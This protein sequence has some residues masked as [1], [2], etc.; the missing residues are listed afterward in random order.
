MSAMPPYHSPPPILR[1]FIRLL[2]ALLLLCQAHGTWAQ[3]GW[4][5]LLGGLTDEQQEVQRQSISALGRSDY[6]GALA[7]LQALKAGRGRRDEEGRFFLQEGATGGAVKVT[8]SG[9][10]QATGNTSTLTKIIITN[11]LR[12]SL[13]TAIAQQQ[14]RAKSPAERLA[15]AQVLSQGPP[16]ALVADM[17]TAL[18]QE[19]VPQIKAMLSLGLA[20]ADLAATDPARR[21]RALRAIE[22]AGDQRFVPQLE[23]LV[24]RDSSGAYAETDPTVRKAAASTLRSLE[25]AALVSRALRDLF[26]GAS[27]GSVLLLAS[28]GL[29]ITFGLMG[30]INMAH[31]ELLM[32]GAYATYQTQELF[33][34]VAPGALDYYLIAAVPVAFIVTMAAGMLLERLV[35]RHLYGRPLETLLATF[36]VSLLLI[37]TVRFVFGAANVSVIT[38][39]YLAGGYT[40]L[41]GLV[42]PYTRIAIVGFVVAVV[43]F[44]WYLL[45]RTALGLQVRVT[46]Q[47]RAMAAC[48][49]MRT[50]RIDMLTFGL[51]SG[52]AGLGGVALSQIG[53]V[54]PELGQGYIVDCFM[55]VV[56]GGVGKL[57]GTVVTSL[58]LGVI[59]KVLEPISGAVL[60]KILVLAFVILFIQRRPQGLFALKG[61]TVEH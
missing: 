48:V 42:I 14:L 32:L 40:L 41:P 19:D 12:R 30:V 11:A 45:N 50:Q 44:V 51:G 1:S 55:V 17:R 54:G 47:N 60:A 26:Y 21:L 39:S 3:A 28:L 59:N 25:R 37:Q 18:K 23:A 24:V 7:V 33:R 27:L 9:A 5:A 4:D 35:L 43:G 16:E 49:G 6:E 15:A 29:A 53:N 8:P 52:V 56:V 22:D 2:P 34:A 10:L 13:S 20:Q 58:G 38:P 57:V 36:G 61:R 31:G 46:T